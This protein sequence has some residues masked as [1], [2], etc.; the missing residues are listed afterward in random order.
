[1]SAAVS[2]TSEETIVSGRVVRRIFHNEVNG[3]TVLAVETKRGDEVIV[4]T[5]T[6]N[7]PTRNEIVTAKGT[8]ERRKGVLQFKAP[9]IT[10]DI[11]RSDAGIVGWLKAQE[12]PGVG[13]RTLMLLRMRFGGRLEEIIGDANA[14]M[15]GGVKKKQAHII[16]DTWRRNRH[17]ATFVAALMEMGLT[18]RNVKAVEEVFGDAALQIIREN[19]WRMCEEVDGIGF[20]TC[21]M[22][23]ERAGLDMTSDI[24]VIAGLRWVLQDNLI[25]NGH[26]GVPEEHLIHHASRLLKVEENA[27]RALM[28]HFIDRRRI[29]RDDLTGLIYPTILHTEECLVA[30]RLLYLR[31]NGIGLATPA[32]A[33][34]ALMAS[35]EKMGLLL[36]RE[37][38]QWD[39]AMAALTEPVAV[40]TGGPGTGKSTI[41][42]VVADAISALGRKAIFAAPTGRAAKRLAET[43]GRDAQTIHKTLEYSAEIGDFTRNEARPL[44]CDAL[45]IDES[46]MMD[47]RISAAVISAIRMGS[48]LLLVGDYDQLPSVGPGQ[49]LRDII[50]SRQIPVVRLT[51][52]RRQA[53]GSG[54]AIAA[55]RVNRGLAPWEG[56]EELP[57]DMICL[58][59]NDEDVPE[60]IMTLVRRLTAAGYRPL[61]D[62]QILASMRKGEAGVNALNARM[63]DLLNPVVE[64]DGESV[65]MDARWFTLRD[66]VMQIRNDY[67]KGVN[68]GEVGN[69]IEVG[70][71]EEGKPFITV[72]FT[73]TKA[74]YLPDT[75]EDVVHAYAVTVHKSQGCEFPCVI[76]AC[77][78]SHRRMLSRNL[79]YTAMT[80]A[81]TK[82]ILVGPKSAMARAAKTEDAFKRYTGL[83]IRLRQ[84][85]D[86]G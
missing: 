59:R 86:E 71:N 39:A 42:K 55:S 46:S 58:D 1:M 6:P 85:G 9:T 27:I 4:V 77:P 47:I 19:P 35:E 76:M 33:E 36:D 54:I 12:I 13:H 2:K 3:Y 62:V 25:R 14:L 60:T 18:A 81:R 20:P 65:H 11:D 74:T 84:E 30:N 45:V 63:K 66:R 48:T 80:R 78:E 72:D 67:L 73:G 40:I 16:A 53:E 51:R 21:D 61:Q 31:D 49:V 57:N 8:W 15:L 23:A 75:I 29:L 26:T 52:V 56:E 10:I 37:G 43:S 38:G 83:A 5:H 7:P 68:N 34:M 79:L 24:R 50:E 28:P 44:A 82:C 70:R 17:R 32:E 64:G 22:V 69:V 41:Q